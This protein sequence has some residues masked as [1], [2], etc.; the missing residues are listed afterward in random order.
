MQYRG[1]IQFSILML[2]VACFVLGMVTAM[3]SMLA[4]TLLVEVLDRT[5]V[6]A[7]SE[8]DLCEFKL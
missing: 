7:E 2:A 8:D 4:L 1:F 3:F 5:R 6:L